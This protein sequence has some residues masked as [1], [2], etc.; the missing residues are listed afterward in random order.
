MVS[1]LY[2]PKIGAIDTPNY[3][4]PQEGNTSCSLL[5]DFDGIDRDELMTEQAKAFP[6]KWE[7]AGNPN[8]E[9]YRCE[10]GTYSPPNAQV[11]TK[12]STTE[13]CH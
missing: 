4:E 12:H 2:S 11:P 8:N 10:D 6:T 5:L 13:S 9:D 1:R 7:V 3:I